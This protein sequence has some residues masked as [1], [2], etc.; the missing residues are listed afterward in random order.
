MY[1]IYQESTVTYAANLDLVANLYLSSVFIRGFGLSGNLAKEDTEELAIARF[2]DMMEAMADGQSVYDT[3]EKVGYWKP[4]P[5]AKTETT[6]THRKKTTTKAPA[7]GEHQ[8]PAP[9]K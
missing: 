5:K 2:N 9:K 1:I 8:E 3:R 4:K 6:T 7:S